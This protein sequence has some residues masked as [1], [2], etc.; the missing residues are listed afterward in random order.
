M[1][2]GRHH[3]SNWLAIAIGLACAVVLWILQPLNNYLFNNTYVADS[4]MPELPL[5]LMAL[6]IL[7]VNPLLRLLA[8]RMALA[9][10]QLALILAVLLVATSPLT[11]LRSWPHTLARSNHEIAADPKLHELHKKM[12]LPDALY[13]EFDR[14]AP[15]GDTPITTPFQEQIEPGASIPWGAWLAPLL[16]WGTLITCSWLLMIGLALVMFPQWRDNERLSFPLLTVQ[17]ELVR[18]PGDGKLLPPLF[19]SGLFWFGFVAIMFIHALNGLS[20]YT[21]GAFPSIPCGYNLRHVF[22]SGIWRHMDGSVTMGRIYFALVGIAYLLPRRIGFSLWFTVIAYQVYRMLGYEY[23]APFHP[24]VGAQRNGAI[25]GFSCML[26]WLSRKQWLAVFR[27]MIR[28]V[29]N[30]VDRRNRTAGYLFTIGSVGILVWHLWAGNSPAFA[31]LALTVLFL[32]S[33]VVARIVAETGM[34][35]IGNDMLAGFFLAMMP[36]Q[37]LSAKIIYLTSMADLVI[38]TTSSRILPVVPAMHGFGLDP[39]RSPREHRNLA[40]GFVAVALLGLLIAGATHV[41]MGYSYDSSLDGQVSPIASWGSQSVARVV[42]RPLLSFDRGSW[43][44]RS[45]DGQG[46]HLAVGLF[47]GIGLQVACIMSPLWPLHPVGLLLIGSYWLNQT[48]FSIFLGW[49]CRSLIT[50]YGGAVVYKKARPLFYGLILGEIFSA[51]LW[52][53][54]P[55]IM[56]ATGFSPS[57][58]TYYRITPG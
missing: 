20:R 8:P 48:W 37:W 10:R 7:A 16:S 30:D 43:P 11:L 45:A 58:I 15:G 3:Y 53:L 32:T 29:G 27:A 28:P 51:I 40:R 52:A 26:L 14:T 47:L 49:T 54:I 36:I 17:Q 38:D 41:W 34:P 33:L 57:E 1:D 6:I 22:A 56:L 9:G 35:F 31:V 4:Y 13:L 19:G 25:I 42:D 2:L 12:D 50:R 39:E 24:G 18:P 21:D 23:S 44:P 46:T 55:V 5:A